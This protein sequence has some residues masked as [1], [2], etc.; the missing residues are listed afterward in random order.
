MAVSVCPWA[1]TSLNVGNFEA[2]E[3]GMI[4]DYSVK[5]YVMS[6]CAGVF[7]PSSKQFIVECAAA[8]DTRQHC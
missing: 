8:A 6:V 2:I 4:I 5:K 1:V 3:T 7:I